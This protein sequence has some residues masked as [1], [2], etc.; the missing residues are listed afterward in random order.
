MK[1]RLYMPDDLQSVLQLFYDS[2][3]TVCKNDYTPE[4]LDAWAPEILDVQRWQDSLNKN[5]TLVAEI[6]GQIV[7][8]ANIGETGYL[9]RLFVDSRYLRQGVA[10]SLVER[11]EKYAKTKGIVFMN[12]ASSITAKPFFEAMGYEA[13][14]VQT[15]ERHGVRL[16]RYLMEKKIL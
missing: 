15:V 12:T 2:V 14:Q 3:H 11:L 1:T 13:I 16:R 4:Q 10:R 5:H 7:G 8:F 9:D 6:D